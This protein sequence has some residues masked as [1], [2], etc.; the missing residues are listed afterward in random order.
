MCTTKLNIFNLILVFSVLSNFSCNNYPCEK[1]PNSYSS[2]EEAIGIIENARFKQEE[3]INTSK[4]SWIRAA[5]Y[6]S[7]DGET[8]CFILETDSKKYIYSGLP[9]DIWQDFKKADSFGG[10]FNKNIKNRYQFKLNN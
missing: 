1:L 6:Y 2:Y 10:Y 9:V 4:S 3:R 8:G 7:C 5:S